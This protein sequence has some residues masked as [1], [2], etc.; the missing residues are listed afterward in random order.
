MKRLYFYNY[1]S[2]ILFLILTPTIF[3][4]LNF[5][6]IWH[7]IYWGAITFVVLIWGFLIL[8]SPI[9]GR[10]GCGWV[11][12]MGTIQD[13][14]SEVSLIRLKW[15]KPKLWLRIIWLLAFFT[16]ASIFFLINLNN[17]KISGITYNPSFL[18]MDFNN[19]YKHIWL[20]D[21][22]GAVLL[23]LLLERRWSCKV[24]PIGSLCATGATFSRLIPVV[25]KSKCNTCS[26]CEKVCLVRVPILEYIK[27]NNGLVTNSECLNC[28]KCV[29]VCKPKAISIKFVWNRKKHLKNSNYA[30]TSNSL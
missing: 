20:Y 17:A 15:T 24:C 14:T 28:G 12:F 9:L 3:R 1:L 25:D 6:F 23:G 8:I 4:A 22:L 21:A 29:E 2:R 26:L 11:C 5:A 18:H 13:F 30:K 10:V 27:E 7:S 16:T 19:H